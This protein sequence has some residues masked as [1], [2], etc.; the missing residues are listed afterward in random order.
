MA[1]KAMLHRRCGRGAHVMFLVVV[2]MACVSKGGVTKHPD[3]AV[4]DSR[5]A[6]TTAPITADADSARV[7]CTDAGGHGGCTIAQYCSRSGQCSECGWC[8]HKLDAFDHTCPPNC[9]LCQKL[10]LVPKAKECFAKDANARRCL[11]QGNSPC[12][13]LREASPAV[14][15]CTYPCWSILLEAICDD[16]D[17]IEVHMH[18]DCMACMPA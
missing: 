2:S 18:L 15:K 7:L 13:C 10:T 16:V 14:R 17:H 8:R 11:V 12:T 6:G 3:D 4:R 1:T 9:E 5:G